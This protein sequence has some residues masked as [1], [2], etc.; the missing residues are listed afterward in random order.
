V[1]AKALVSFG[2]ASILWFGG[3]AAVS[4]QSNWPTARKP[5]ATQ[6]APPAK[7]RKTPS[8]PAKRRTLRKPEVRVDEA[9][10]RTLSEMIARQTLAIEAL[11]LRLE[12]ADRRLDE[13][14]LSTPASISCTADPF[15]ATRTV[16]W[17]QVVED[18]AR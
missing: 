2:L 1:S 18:V 11:T 13:A 12:A 14:K 17:V 9:A 15:Q 7:S 6:P 3:P 8:R 4:A 5:A 16:D 10:L